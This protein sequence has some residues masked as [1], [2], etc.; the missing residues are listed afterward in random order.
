[1]V[2]GLQTGQTRPQP[3]KA[4]PA[5]LSNEAIALGEIVTWADGL[6]NW[7]Q[8]AIRRLCLG[9]LSDTDMADMQALCTGATKTFEGVTEKH[10]PDAKSSKA[11]VHLT[12][13]KDVKH[14]NM[15]AEGEHLTFFKKGMTVIYGDNGAGK[16]GYIRILKKACRA[17][18]PKDD[19]IV[20]NIYANATGTPTAL[21]QYVENGNNREATWTSGQS[22]DA[23]L[24]AVS[25]FDSRTANVHV[26]ATNHVAYTPFPL[27][28]LEDLAAACQAIKQ[29]LNAQIADIEKQTPA[30]LCNPAC[31]PET[32]V[33]KLIAALSA[34]TKPDTVTAL[35]TL[36]DA[37]RAR[38][39]Q[40]AADLASDPVKA[41]RALQAIKDRLDTRIAALTKLHDAASDARAAGLTALRATHHAAAEAAA[42][43]AGNLFT[44]DPL[45]AIGSAAWVALWQAAR[46]YARTQAY[47][48]TEFPKTEDG[49]RCVLCQQELSNEA[50]DRLRR[51][52]E[53][54]RDESK[55]IEENARQAVEDEHQRLAG[56]DLTIAT[57]RV[58]VADIRNEIG[59]GTLGDDV[60]RAALGAKWRLRA[61]LRD[62]EA[63]PEVAPLPATA[64]AAA[65]ERL[66]ERVVALQS[67]GNTPA[68]KALVAELAEL[69]DR[70]W[71]SAVRADV[72]AEIE[73]KGQI[74]ALKN[75]VKDTATNSITAKSSELAKTLVTNALR[76]RF[77]QEIGKLGVA[78][79]AVELQQD[80]VALGAP[81]FRLALIKK[82]EA[83]LGEIL[84]EGEHRCIAIAAFLAELSTTESRSALV[85]DDPVS[86]L[87][88]M[89]RE[90]LSARFAEEA[91]TRQVVIFTHDVAFLFLLNEAC[92]ATN[93]DINFRSI[94]RGPEKAGFCHLNPPPN[95]QPVDKV[96]ESLDQQLQNQKVQYERGDQE[97]WYRTVR[98]L[99]EQLRTTWERAVEEAVAPVIKRLAN[100]IDTT[101]LSKLTALTMTDCEAM[102]AAFGRC[103][104]LLHS[105]AESLNPPLPKPEAIQSEID[106]LRG[107]VADIR[108]RQDAIDGV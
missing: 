29:R 102:R 108:Q 50:A 9:A 74:A 22:T 20:P 15:L 49:A 76:S 7:Q 82:P 88:H 78:G 52:D 34:R 65:S 42:A 99:Q 81:L 104:K 80:K 59:D 105:S 18:S 87:D 61:Q 55:K 11:T 17:R 27:K 71:L 57:L 37:E 63:K 2:E 25:V 70:Q 14:V 43:A 83:R 64:L 93:A 91:L 98:S 69:Q 3:A 32:K 21:V 60:R 56:S 1:M 85:F 4:A 19:K 28:L 107:W 23:A 84:S 8:D 79:L 6:P 35:A 24:S 68:R 36:S 73:R 89:H 12:G 31:S 97:A 38:M 39:E 58:Y 66:R 10:I 96:I 106:A 26:D 46:A 86:S 67:E 101:G 5:P 48:G 75:A 13:I 94:T 41:S 30:S 95:A 62:R 47:P 53:F 45:P 16:S 51:F 33:G 54:V 72:L 100:K 40:V 44:A 77:A 90:A 92:R 103:S